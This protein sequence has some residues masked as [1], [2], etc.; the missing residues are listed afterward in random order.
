[1]HERNRYSPFW[2]L[3]VF[4]AAGVSAHP[5]APTSVEHSHAESDIKWELDPVKDG[6]QA[7]NHY[8]NQW[9]G[10][11]GVPE[12][13]PFDVLACW[14]NQYHRFSDQI[15]GQRLDF[16]HCHINKN[17][18]IRRQVPTYRFEGSSWPADA[19]Q[20]VRDAFLK[21]SSVTSLAVRVG[22]QFVES[23]SG[24]ANVTVKYVETLPENPPDNLTGAW[25]PGIRTLFFKD[26]DTWDF[27]VSPS[28]IFPG[29]HHFYS[30]AIHEVGHV[31]GFDHSGEPDSVMYI[32]PDHDIGAPKN[33]DGRHFSDI[34]TIDREALRNLYGIPNATTSAAPLCEIYFFGCNEHDREMVFVSFDVPGF[35][36][37]VSNFVT[38]KKL[39]DGSWSTIRSLP[40]PACV[41]ETIFSRT[42]VYR[43]LMYSILG[44][45]E[46]QVTYYS[47]RENCNPF[48]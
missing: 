40:T 10:L 27:S 45:S 7:H 11:G 25:M 28:G 1:M 42:T 26:I 18:I 9:Y 31:F 5:P 2:F 24:S 22:A 33:Q 3:A 38:Q 30:V 19:K 12:E 48:P 29:D 37:P 8:Q 43:T 46:C 36:Y 17:S 16:A 23:T 47:D 15:I 32:D 21:W 41:A 13:R 14:D 4:L 39:P 6:D 20:R 35:G 44:T 34:D